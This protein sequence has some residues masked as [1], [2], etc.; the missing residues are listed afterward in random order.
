MTARPPNGGHA[1][2]RGAQDGAAGPFSLLALGRS[3]VNNL[4]RSL[5]AAWVEESE[6]EEKWALGF[7]RGRR[8]QFCSAGFRVWPLDEV[9]RLT[10]CGPAGAAQV[11]K[12]NPGPGP[13]R[14]LRAVRAIA[15]E[16]G[17]GLILFPGHFPAMNSNMSYFSFLFR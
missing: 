8:R 7:G 16:K 17:H 6:G 14:G 2:W 12:Q 15:R 13:R 3:S 11:G 10:M 5:V 1:H 4:D 9:G